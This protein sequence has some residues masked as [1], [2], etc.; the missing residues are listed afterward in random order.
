MIKRYTRP[1]MTAI[2][3]DETKY[4]NLLA[5]EL[6]I[7][8]AREAE[9]QIPTGVTRRIKS[10]LAEVSIAEIA[11]RALWIET[12]PETGTGH[13]VQSFVDAVRER[14]PEDLRRYFHEITTS[15]DTTEPALFMTICQAGEIILK[16]L[17]TLRTALRQLANKYRLVPKIGRTHTQHGIPSIVGLYFLWWY[18]YID[19]ARPAFRRVLNQ[20]R[21]GKVRGLVGTYDNGLTPA[22]EARALKLLGLKPVKVCGQI[23]LRDRFARVM[24]E[25]AVIAGLLENMA[26]NIRLGAQTEVREMSEPFGKGRKGSSHSPH[27][28]NTDRSE[29]VTGL[30]RVVRNYAGTGLENIVT[31]WERDISHSG[32]ERIIVEGSFQLVAFMLY[33]MTGI[34]EGLRVNEEQIAHNLNLTCGITNSAEV[35]T[36]LMGHGLEPESAYRLAQRLAFQAFETQQPYLQLL[37]IS[38]EVPEQ[39]K[40][41]PLQACFELEPKLKHIPAIFSR[42]GL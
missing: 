25:L 5:V 6:A 7:C 28:Q 9:Q 40:Q 42:F 11:K 35:K 19:R 18:D 4:Q 39:A 14:L 3:S 22:V 15:T 37:L 38:D 16:Q 32:P 27:K 34:I 24:N 41:G 1:D 20:T 23:I 13:D 8:Q 31:W 10:A 21:V 26:V 2:F 12:N 30:A 36:V 29:N 17:D 33:R